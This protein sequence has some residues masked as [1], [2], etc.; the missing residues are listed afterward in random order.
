[1]E[2]SLSYMLSEHSRV[3]FESV[4]KRKQKNGSAMLSPVIC[5]TCVCEHVCHP[6]DLQGSCNR[7]VIVQTTRKIPWK[8]N[9]E[10]EVSK[11]EAYWG[12]AAHCLRKWGRLYKHQTLMDKVLYKKKSNI[13]GTDMAEPCVDQRKS[14]RESSKS[15]SGKELIGEKQKSGAGVQ[16]TNINLYWFP[17]KYLQ[18]FSQVWRKNS[19]RKERDGIDNSLNFSVL[20]FSLW[21]YSA[22]II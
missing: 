2:L 18:S 19:R 6:R 12:P 17:M 14:R 11:R 21:G 1:M 5:D 4:W 10:T 7:Y 13:F 20:W 9:M 8:I 3:I 16:S 15:G 22:I